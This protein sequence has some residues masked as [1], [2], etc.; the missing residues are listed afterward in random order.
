[1][2]ESDLQTFLGSQQLVAVCFRRLLLFAS[3]DPN[4]IHDPEHGNPTGND[5]FTFSSRS[6]FGPEKTGILDFEKIW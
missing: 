4:L 3:H 6:A 1:V 5:F 2:A